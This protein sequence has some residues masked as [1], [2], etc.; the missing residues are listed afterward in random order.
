MLP[1]GVALMLIETGNAGFTLRVT[2]LDV[3]GLPV[4]QAREEV[5]TA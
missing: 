2:V 4:A 5:R 3:A 1:D